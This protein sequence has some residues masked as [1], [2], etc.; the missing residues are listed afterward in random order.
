[1]SR[2]SFR[3]T[4]LQRVAAQR[5]VPKLN[6]LPS[7]LRDERST[8]PKRSQ[9]SFTLPELNEVVPCTKTRPQSVREIE[10]QPSVGTHHDRN[11]HT[12]NVGTEHAAECT[13]RQPTRP[14]RPGFLGTTK[15]PGFFAWVTNAT[16]T[17]FQLTGFCPYLEF[18]SC[19]KRRT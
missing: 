17:V 14:C 9:Q 3:L 8:G 7:L 13:Q 10:P 6:Q 12:D 16:R 19:P 11:W 2:R 15:I 1:M 18:L 5:D 4:N